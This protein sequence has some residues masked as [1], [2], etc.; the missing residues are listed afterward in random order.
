MRQA[1][2]A[3]SETCSRIDW[4]KTVWIRWASSAAQGVAPSPIDTVFGGCDG[5]D[6]CDGCENVVM[7]L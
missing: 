2:A 5:C 6:G 4:R 7:M 3:A 1:L